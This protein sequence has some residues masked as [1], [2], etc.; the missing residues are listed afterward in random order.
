M[1]RY[2]IRQQLEMTVRAVEQQSMLSHDHVI[3][4]LRREFESDS[5]GWRGPPA[6]SGVANLFNELVPIVSHFD[7][8][9]V[10]VTIYRS[11]RLLRSI[12]HRKLFHPLEL[13]RRRRRQ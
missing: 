8:D 2:Q 13:A 10:S 6:A 3:G 12:G 4:L 1:T 5:S 7:C 11:V 9:V